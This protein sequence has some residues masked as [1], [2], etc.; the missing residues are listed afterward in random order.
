MTYTSTGLTV[1]KW[2]HPMCSRCELSQRRARICEIYPKGIPAKYLRKMDDGLDVDGEA[3]DCPDYKRAT[4]PRRWTP[5]EWIKMVEDLEAEIEAKTITPYR[6]LTGG[7]AMWKHYTFENATPL[8]SFIE[9]HKQYW[10]GKT[11]DAFYVAYSRQSH[12]SWR[13]VGKYYF[14]DLSYAFIV[15]EHAV[16]V[17]YFFGYRGCQAVTGRGMASIH[18]R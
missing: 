7:I 3:Q 1:E 12:N 6:R 5:P 9:K 18:R 11:I 10:Q 15:G 8:R 16:I 13:R 14:E 17:R 4:N 2:C